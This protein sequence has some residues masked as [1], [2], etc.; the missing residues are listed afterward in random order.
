MSRIIQYVTIAALSITGSLAFFENS[1]RPA[2]D[3]FVVENFA[4]IE[5]ALQQAVR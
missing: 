1:I 5:H 2:L 3:H 4:V